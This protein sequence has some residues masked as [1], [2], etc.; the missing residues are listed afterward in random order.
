MSAF[1]RRGD[2]PN[3]SHQRRFPML[4]RRVLLTAMA[5]TLAMPAFAQTTRNES[6]KDASKEPSADGGAGAGK[7]GAA[8]QKH[9]MDTMAVGSMSLVASRIAVKKVFRRI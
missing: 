5:A 1:H 3:P 6:A 7:M 8:E 2:K 9:M 4:E